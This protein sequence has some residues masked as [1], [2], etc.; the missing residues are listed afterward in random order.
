MFKLSKAKRAVD[1]FVAGGASNPS[2]SLHTPVQ[3]DATLVQ[4][5]IRGHDALKGAF[6]TL[7]SR[8]DDDPGALASA[9]RDCADRLHALR[10]TESL[11]LYPVIARCVDTDPA[12]RRGLMQLRLTILGLYRKIQRRLDELLQSTREGSASAA[13]VAL[14]SAA[15][16]E[17]L[18]RS[19][20]EIY[21]LYS[22]VRLQT[23]E[24]TARAA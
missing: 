13:A 19:E 21:P 9:A 4:R 24:V 10:C 22:L 18:Q 12:A 16:T 11:W 20:S 15:L 2:L 3:F 6:A 17:Y 8:I 7:V 14:L 5:L 23:T 1:D